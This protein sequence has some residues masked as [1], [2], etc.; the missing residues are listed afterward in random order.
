MPES[1]PPPYEDFGDD[2]GD[3]GRSA[4]GESLRSPRGLKRGRDGTV[5]GS[6]M[7]DIARAMVREGSVV[8]VIG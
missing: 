2:D 7:G 4:F 5:R 3:A 8:E 1:S 6:G